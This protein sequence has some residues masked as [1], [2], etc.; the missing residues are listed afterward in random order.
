MQWLSVA[1]NEI[2]H[3][4]NSARLIEKFGLP[5]DRKHAL[6]ITA[7]VLPL[8]E[9]HLSTQD[10]LALGRPSIAD[11]AVFPYLALAWEGG[12][13]LDQNPAIQAWIKRLKALPGYIGMPGIE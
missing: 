11:C 7:R 10:W 9:Q 12:V 5:L 13:T 4:P 3:G 6:D 1:A 2:H 8:I